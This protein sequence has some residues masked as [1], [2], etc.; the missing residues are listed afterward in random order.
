M[1]RLAPG[2]RGL[3]ANLLHGGNPAQ[4]AVEGLF[5][6]LAFP[7]RANGARF[8]LSRH[9]YI[10]LQ[11]QDWLSFRFNQLDPSSDTETFEVKGT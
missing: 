8:R 11:R 10:L 4:Q 1:G 2:R 6:E 9:I 3:C 5:L 7:R